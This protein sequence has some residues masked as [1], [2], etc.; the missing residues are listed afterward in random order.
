MKTPLFRKELPQIRT[1]V[2]KIGSRILTADGHI[3]RVKRLVED[4]AKLHQAGVKVVL[5]SSGAIAHGMK[6]LGYKKRPKTIPLQQALASIGQNRLMNMYQSIFEKY[7]IHIGQVLLT[8]DDLRSKKRYLNLRNTLFHLLACDAVPIVNENDSVGVE[9]IQ[10]GNNDTLGAQIS[11][12]VHA[13]LFVNLTDVSGLYDKNPRTDKSATHIPVVQSLSSGIQKLASDKKNDI[14]VGG[15]STKLKSADMVT[16]AGTFALIGDGF[17]QRLLTVLKDESC[18]TLFMPSEK[19][20][21]SRHRWIAF[22]GQS[23]GSVTVDDGAARALQKRGKSLLAAGVV[24]VEGTFKTGDM[25]DILNSSADVI[26]R[27]MVNFDTSEIEQIKGRKSSEIERMLGTIKFS[28]V[29]HRDNMVV[30][31]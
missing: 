27:G 7:G 9:E 14:S 24:S 16:R 12:L 15:M 26:A 21:S 31:E 8:W 30:M 10:F 2:V 23:A 5:V 11:L 19:K 22:S 6:S 20:M 28:E 1:L 13:D 25:V 18:A 29:I 4:M 3:N 17:N